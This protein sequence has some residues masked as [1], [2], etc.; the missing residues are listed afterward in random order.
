MIKELFLNKNFFLLLT[1]QFVSQLGDKFY[2]IALAWWVL[3]KTGSP[4]IMGIIIFCSIFPEIITSFISGYFVDN[5]GKKRIIVFCDLIRGFLMLLGSALFFGNSL[6]ISHIILI[7]T[8]I[9][10]SSS[11]FNPAVQSIYPLILNNSKIKAGQSLSQL[12]YGVT[13]VFGPV[14]GSILLGFTGVGFIFLING[15]SYIISGLSEWFIYFEEKAEK[16]KQDFKSSFKD[17]LFFILKNREILIT[18]MLIGI[19]HFFIGS[20]QL[21]LPIISRLFS[22]ENPIFLGITES[23]MGF[24]FIIGSILSRFIKKEYFRTLINISMILGIVFFVSGLIITLKL[25]VIILLP[26][27]VILTGA[28]VSNASI[29][30]NSFLHKKTPLNLSGRVFSISNMTGNFSLPVSIAVT[31]ILIE[32]TGSGMYLI[33]MGIVLSLITIIIKF[34]ILKKGK[35]NLNGEIA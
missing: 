9:S 18:V 1:G 20:F 8:A 3:E 7:S 35:S 21:I 14:F 33:L 10:I 24:G 4:S 19:V 32:T 28:S 6:E 16:S 17:G 31:G 22:Q 5:Y 27:F 34:F 26:I 15:I 23:S 25:M 11:F 29:F 2:L 12:A 13:S 30:W